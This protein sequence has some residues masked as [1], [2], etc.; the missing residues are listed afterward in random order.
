MDQVG[1][2]F[3]ARAAFAGDQNRH[4]ARRDAFDGVDD[5]LH[6][7]AAENR[8]G[9]AAHRFQRPAQ[10]AVFLALFLEDVY[11][12]QPLRWVSEPAPDGRRRRRSKS[13]C[14]NAWR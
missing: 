10:A 6:R 1:D 7:A 9:I 13:G 8:G 14:G 11:K 2:D 5:V 3:L 4:V 12:R